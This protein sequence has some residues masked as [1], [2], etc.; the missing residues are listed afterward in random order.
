VKQ[1]LSNIQQHWLLIV[2]NAER[3]RMHGRKQRARWLGGDSEAADELESESE[4]IAGIFACTPSKRT[5]KLTTDFIMFFM[6]TGN[7]RG[8]VVL[9]LDG[10]LRF[11]ARAQTLRFKA[12]G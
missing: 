3:F 12:R 5:A 10:P 9:F 4:S 6:I 2:D 1:W 7:T 11:K 8:K